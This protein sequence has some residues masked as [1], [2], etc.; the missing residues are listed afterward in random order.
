MIMVKKLG[1]YHG[2][3]SIYVITRWV[4]KGLISWFNM[5]R[6]V[7]KD[8]RSSALSDIGF[9]LRLFSIIAVL[10]SLML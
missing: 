8:I 3:L 10:F 5:A 4:I 9:L 1:V 7:C 2:H 6:V